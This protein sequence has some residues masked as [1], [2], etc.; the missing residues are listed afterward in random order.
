M[1]SIKIDISKRQ[2]RRQVY[3][4]ISS[5]VVGVLLAFYSCWCQSIPLEKTISILFVTCVFFVA[6]FAANHHSTG[7]IIV[8]VRISEDSITFDYR[9]FCAKGE[10]TWPKEK[11]LIKIK[12]K[13]NYSKLEFILQRSPFPHVMSIRHSKKEWFST[14]SEK[15]IDEILTILYKYNYMVTM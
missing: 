7:R 1:N 13:A 11:T 2:I 6:F 3:I 8:G 4:F 10:V 12:R 5:F 15:N 9:Y 14:C